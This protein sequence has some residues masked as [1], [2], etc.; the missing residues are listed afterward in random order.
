VDV[1]RTRMTW[2]CY[3][4]FLDSDTTRALT[5]EASCRVELHFKQSLNSL[6]KRKGQLENQVLPLFQSESKE[7][8]MP[9][10]SGW[11][12]AR[13]RF[14]RKKGQGVRHQVINQNA[15][16]PPR[17]SVA[18]PWKK[19]TKESKALILPQHNHGQAPPLSISLSHFLEVNSLFKLALGFLF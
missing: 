12:Q 9:C 15:P 13:N 2:L 16:D 19:G 1:W 11:A 10:E 14:A 3:F 5:F 7:E 17:V 4:L 6:S 18:S 8:R